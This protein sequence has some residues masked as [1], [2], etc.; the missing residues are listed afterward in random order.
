MLVASSPLQS[1]LV[2]EPVDVMHPSHRPAQQEWILID[3]NGDESVTV[4]VS[5]GSRLFFSSTIFGRWLGE[6]IYIY[7]FT[8]ADS[9]WRTKTAKKPGKK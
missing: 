2:S 7:I 5:H 8:F 1:T 4:Q 9:V 3:V 6:C